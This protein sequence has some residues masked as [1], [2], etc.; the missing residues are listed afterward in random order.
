MIP[1]PRLLSTDGT[2]DRDTIDLSPC[3]D[4]LKVVECDGADVSAFGF[5]VPAALRSEKAAP[6]WV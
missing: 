4:A 3:A 1:D 6:N 2:D 5:D